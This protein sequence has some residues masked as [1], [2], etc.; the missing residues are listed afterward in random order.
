V[1]PSDESIKKIIY[2]ALKNA[3]KKWT[4]PI[5]NLPLALNQFEIICG[6]FKQDLL[7][8]KF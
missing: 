3:A 6:D 2:L 1:F 8:H 4:M 7:E 5:K